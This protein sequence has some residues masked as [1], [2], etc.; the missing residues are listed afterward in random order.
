MANSLIGLPV[1][2]TLHHPPGTAIHGVVAAVNP[3]T[4]TLTLHEGALLPDTS[5]EQS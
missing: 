2:V 3:H 5:R 1:I 4:S